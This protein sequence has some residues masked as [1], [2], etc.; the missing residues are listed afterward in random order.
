M[1]AKHYSVAPHSQVAN[2]FQVY[3][4]GL[5]RQR[6]LVGTY[7]RDEAVAVC[8]ALMGELANR[9]VED[10][11]E[12][13]QV[14]YAR[15]V[16]ECPQCKALGLPATMARLE[17]ET[18]CVGYLD[19]PSEPGQPPHHHDPNRVGLGFRCAAGHVLSAVSGAR[20]RC[21]CGHPAAAGEG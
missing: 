19:P 18:T 4:H 13:E 2:V 8:N 17:A 7:G 16:V 5:P 21:W 10:L 6:R 20:W 9:L 11:V 15:G 1:K 3:A 14:A 12:S